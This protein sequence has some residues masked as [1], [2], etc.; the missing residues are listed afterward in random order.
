M[1][2]RCFSSSQ[3]MI[4]KVV[5]SPSLN[6]REGNLGIVPQADVWLMDAR[7]YRRLF[8]R[9]CGCLL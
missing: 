5:R 3:E 2:E 7:R 4:A 9:F 8:V 1:A 6:L